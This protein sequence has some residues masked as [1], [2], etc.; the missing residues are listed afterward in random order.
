MK[1][2]QRITEVETFTDDGRADATGGCEDATGG[3]EDVTGGRADGDRMIAAWEIVSATVSFLIAAW[4]VRPLTGN[5]KLLGAVPLAFALILL[6]LS[7][8]ARGE[9]ARDLGWRVD[10]FFAAARLLLLPVVATCCVILL[11]GWQQGQAYS[12]KVQ[13]WQWLLWLPAWALAQ[14]YVLQGFINRRAQLLWGRGYRSVLLVALVFALLHL[15]N[16][17]LTLI[18]FLGGLL[19]AAVYQRVPNLFALALT[20]SLISLLLVWALPLT[21]LRSLRIGFNYFG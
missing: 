3:R 17:W 7:H 2:K 15:P 4:A 13:Q 8:R 6:L 19:L 21:M 16:P 11:V 5:T 1:A 18:T 12:G 20:H 9:T 10:N 14:Q